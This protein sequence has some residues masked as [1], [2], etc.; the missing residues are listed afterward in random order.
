MEE[1]ESRVDAKVEQETYRSDSRAGQS[2]HDHAPAT[3]AVIN[4]K[5]CDQIIL[6]HEHQIAM[7]VRTTNCCNDQICIDTSL[8]SATAR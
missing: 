4:T 8:M 2:A 3:T 6:L 5:Q 7:S 1:P